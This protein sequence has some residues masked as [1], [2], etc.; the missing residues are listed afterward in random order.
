MLLKQPRTKRILSGLSRSSRA[1]LKDASNSS[2][3]LIPP[4]LP[5]SMLKQQRLRHPGLREFC[6]HRLRIRPRV[7]VKVRITE[8][9]SEVRTV[10]GQLVSRYLAIRFKAV[11][12]GQL[13]YEVSPEDLSFTDEPILRWWWARWDRNDCRLLSPKQKVALLQM[14]DGRIPRSVEKV[15]LLLEEVDLLTD[16]EIGHTFDGRSG[17]VEV[18]PADRLEALESF[19]LESSR[20]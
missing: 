7:I 9:R 17:L 3:L 8:E 14:T 11:C 20:G 5:L 6:L 13:A 19:L 10:G 18:I 4:S 15:R 2:Q 12:R 1:L 16:R